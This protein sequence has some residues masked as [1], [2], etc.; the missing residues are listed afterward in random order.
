MSQYLLLPQEPGIY[1][2]L[3]NQ[4]TVLY[5]G[6][7]KNLKKRVASYF[8]SGDRIGPKTQAVISQA[9]KIR[10]IVVESEIESLLLEAAYI[11]KYLPRYN[12]RM[13]DG[14]SYPLIKVTKNKEYPSVFTVREIVNDKAEYFGPFPDVSSMRLVLRILRRIFPYQSVKNHPNKKCLYFHLGLC[15]CTSAFQ[16]SLHK[17]EYKKTILYILQILRG[18]SKKVMKKLEK[19]RNGLTNKELFEEAREVQKQLDALYAVTQ[20]VKRPFEYEQ[21]PNLKVDLRYQELEWLKKHLH[22][23]GVFVEKLSKIE[24]YDISTIQGAFSTASLVVFT[25]G[26]KNSSLY[27]RFRIKTVGSISKPNDFAMMR[28]VLQRRFR[29]E[30]WEFPNLIIVDGGKGQ[31][32]SALE[33]LTRNNLSIPLVGLAKREET[34]ITSDFKEIV[35]PKSSPALQLVMRIR[36]EAHR[37]AITYHRKLRLKAAFI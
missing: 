26:E 34:I 20:P 10:I 1:F 13:T 36:D 33:I 32:S 24:C 6:K 12:I 7:A 8:T 22:N 19:E 28:E 31:I 29:H 4:N 27:R 17:K 3:D 35:L 16:D 14:K 21:N 2:F 23:A 25:D 37:F 9:R 15:P 11:K 30:E 5:V 18:Q